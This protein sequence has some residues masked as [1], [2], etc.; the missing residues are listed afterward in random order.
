MNRDTSGQSRRHRYL[1]IAAFAAAVAALLA[2]GAMIWLACR[3]VNQVLDRAVP[4]ML[5][6]AL[7]QKFEQESTTL[8]FLG[9]FN[10]GNFDNAYDLTTEQ[11]QRR[12]SLEEFGDFVKLHPEMQS[13]WV[14]MT[15]EDGT[16]D[17]PIYR[18]TTKT[19][20]QRITTFRLR[21]RKEG[22]KWK[23]DEIVLPQ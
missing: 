1:L 22:A 5:H 3:A 11:F 13:G 18:I 6:E 19:D 4:A 12:Y 7:E 14:E 20:G 9:N 23:V 15:Y 16:V 8:G 17:S 2:C 10:P 21:L